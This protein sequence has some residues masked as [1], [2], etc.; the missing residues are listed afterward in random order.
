VRTYSDRNEIARAGITDLEYFFSARNERE[1]DMLNETISIFEPVHVESR[2][3]VRAAQ[4]QRILATKSQ[5]GRKPP[6]LLVAAVA[7]D[8]GFTVL[9]Y[10]AD[11]DLIADVTGQSCQWVIP[12]GTID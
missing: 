11:F 6:D 10:D 9:H 8:L 1:W 4:V 7:E 12:A 5:R 3:F 2:H